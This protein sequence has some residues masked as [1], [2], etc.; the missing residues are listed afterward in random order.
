M[1][2]GHPPPI[3]ISSNPHPPN[4]TKKS[5]LNTITT[6]NATL[7]PTIPNNN[8]T[9]PY[10]MHQPP[11]PPPHHNIA[12]TE[13]PH[14]IHQP[15]PIPMMMHQPPLPPPQA[16]MP[17]PMMMPHHHHPPP[18]PNMAHQ[19]P[20]MMYQPP[21]PPQAQVCMPPH[22]M[23]PPPPPPPPPQP[24][25]PMMLPYGLLSPH[26]SLTPSEQQRLQQHLS[27]LHGIV[28]P[29]N[30][31]PTAPPLEMPPHRFLPHSD[32]DIMTIGERQRYQESISKLDPGMTA[33]LARAEQ[34]SRAITAE[35]QQQQQQLSSIAIAQQQLESE[36]S[37]LVPSGTITTASKAQ[38]S[39][40][41]KKGLLPQ[42]QANLVH[43]PKPRT[44]LA[45][46][47]YSDDSDNQHYKFED[48]EDDSEDDNSEDDGDE[49]VGAHIYQSSKTA[50]LIND[51]KDV[52][53]G[54]AE[55]LLDLSA[56]IASKIMDN[57]NKNKNDNDDDGDDNDNGHKEDAGIG[58]IHSPPAKRK[59]EDITSS[60]T[61]DDNIE[62]NDGRKDKLWAEPKET[63][64][65][66]ICPTTG[67]E[68]QYDFN[69][70]T[71]TWCQ[72]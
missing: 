30:Y 38:L 8:N 33:A 60:S 19:P 58:I 55:Y 3:P 49:A 70:N 27:S 52:I 39:D 62:T 41:H 66:Q 20:P 64:V 2:K 14:M 46:D 24:Q 57:N 47:T 43:V 17:P 12:P 15:P 22:L 42:V 51:E 18:P 67:V 5:S 10:A 21:P 36:S 44:K 7:P 61:E 4:N 56:K 11:P 29:N 13:Y 65:S 26:S 35:Q 54:N 40:G 69:S 71:S 68:K 48:D 9:I 45:T 59:R 72:V 6:N 34:L 32:S 37:L 1:E 50:K 16:C 31:A 25:Q 53:K 28:L 23:M 63:T